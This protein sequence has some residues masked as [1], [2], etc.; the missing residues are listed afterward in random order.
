[1]DEQ[2]KAWEGQRKKAQYILFTVASFLDL[3]VNVNS[4]TCTILGLKH[5][6]NT[7]LIVHSINDNTAYYNWLSTGL[8][9][10]STVNFVYFNVFTW[11]TEPFLVTILQHIVYDLQRRQQYNAKT[12]NVPRQECIVWNKRLKDVTWL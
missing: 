6:I 8:L 4:K 2:I 1:M 11:S 9:S 5:F 7:K 12:I 10:S 3:S